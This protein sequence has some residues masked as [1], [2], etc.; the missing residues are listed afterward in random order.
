M[1]YSYNDIVSQLTS[2]V[3]NV[4]F[5][6]VDGSQREMECTLLP[7]YLP[8]EYRNRSPM[9]TEITGNAISVWDVRA[10]AWRSF[11]VDS[12]ISIG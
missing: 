1:K 4:T 11:R 10:G 8:E 7:S 2:G 12:V 5:T 3:V 6:K 9:L